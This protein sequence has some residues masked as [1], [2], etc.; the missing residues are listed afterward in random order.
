MSLEKIK[1]E[2]IKG[3]I[4]LIECTIDG[5]IIDSDNSL[6]TLNKGETLADMSPFFYSVVALFPDIKKTIHIPCVNI[7]I[8]TISK[9]L[10]IEIRSYKD[11]F[12]V[13]L[14]DF[15]EHYQD[16]QPLVQEKNEASIQ[17]NKLHYERILMEEKEKFKNRFISR[18]NHEIRN[19]LNS[20]LGFMEVLKDTKL[21]YQQN[22]TLAI[23]KKTGN[24]IKMLMDDILD[25]SKIETG[26]LELRNA[27]FNLYHILKNI[28][29]H[30][31]LKNNVKPIVFSITPEKGIPT[32]LIGDPLRLNQI[33]FNLI[34]N[35]FRNTAKGRIDLVISA[36]EIAKNKA[37]LHF[38][39]KD[40]GVGISKD[41]IDEIFSSYYRIQLDTIKPIG[42][43]LGLKIVKDL[44]MLQNGE[45]TV[46]SK[47]GV[48]TTFHVTIPYTTRNNIR[49]KKT[50]PKGSG[51]VISKRILIIEDEEINQMLFMKLFLNNDEGYQI[52]IS[53]N[54][55]E[56]KERLKIK[57]FSL[58][59][60]KSSNANQDVFETIE[61]I[62]SLN[63]DSNKEIPILMVSGSSM[64]HEQKRYKKAGADAFLAKPYTKKELF[65][66]IE[67]LT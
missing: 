21:D 42:E 14:F 18:L 4:Q 1:N 44:V 55:I 16:S 30:F 37:N 10:D 35:A 13:L 33:L 63:K 54:A 43:G 19:P 9:I 22:E 39:I 67:E 61:S 45:I 15:T 3:K 11:H 5:V 62:K 24:H 6:F 25:I 8:T 48:G 29:N 20:L 32:K 31:G 27:N 46:E 52:E 57:K 17:R 51:I 47:E 41:K 49:E 60:L 65:N 36:T 38:S 66:H 23:I 64:L 26:E 34:E 58:I 7:E 50:V 12:L 56:A 59:I 40:T 53:S 28:E 2:F